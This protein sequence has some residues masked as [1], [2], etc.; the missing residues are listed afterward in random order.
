[1]LF[2]LL[3]RGKQ[4]AEQRYVK[5]V[6]AHHQ[7]EYDSSIAGFGRLARFSAQEI[8]MQPA[9]VALFAQGARASGQERDRLRNAL[10][11][12]LL[13]SYNNLGQE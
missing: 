1:M 10:C 9:A 7:G 4:R 12:Q 2:G 8:F 13:P 6:L 5:S 11:T 3:F